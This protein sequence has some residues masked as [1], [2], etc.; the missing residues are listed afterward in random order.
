MSLTIRQKFL[1]S[2]IDSS[3]GKIAS[4]EEIKKAKQLARGHYWNDPDF[5]EYYAASPTGKRQ[6]FEYVWY[7][8]APDRVLDEWLRR[9]KKAAKLWAQGKYKESNKIYNQTQDL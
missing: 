9:A 4:P 8:W 1:A 2:W 5:S 7:S 6:G 3:F